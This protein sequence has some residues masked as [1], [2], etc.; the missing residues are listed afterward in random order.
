MADLPKPD[1]PVLQIGLSGFCTQTLVMI[2]ID[3]AKE[4]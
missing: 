4:T 1:H 3:L 2:P